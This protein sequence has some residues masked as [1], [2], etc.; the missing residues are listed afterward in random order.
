[1][2]CSSP[3]LRRRAQAPALG[4][5]QSCD[6]VI[7]TSPS[8]PWPVPLLYPSNA[9]LLLL[10]IACS[11]FNSV[12]QKTRIQKHSASIQTTSNTGPE[13]F[14]LPFFLS[15]LFPFLLPPS[16]PPSLSSILLSF[17][18][19]FLFLLF[20]PLLLLYLL[21]LCPSLPGS[22]VAVI[23]PFICKFSFNLQGDWKFRA[24][25]GYQVS[26][27]AAWTTQ[28]DLIIKYKQRKEL[29]VQP[30]G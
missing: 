28:W 12:D 11:C 23:L 21:S 13:H 17:L 20:F 18:S 10:Q 1:M 26:L 2:T 30:S 24:S 9:I 3:R 22:K 25:L 4:F 19:F 14:P 16:F 15:F 27:R 29:I 7:L 6:S 8:L 5:L